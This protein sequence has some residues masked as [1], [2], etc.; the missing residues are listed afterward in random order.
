MAR[1]RMRS[2][3]EWLVNLEE[4]GSDEVHTVVVYRLQTAMDTETGQITLRKLWVVARGYAGG[5]ACEAYSA[6]MYPEADGHRLV[7]CPYAYPDPD[8]F[9]ELEVGYLHADDCEVI[10]SLWQK[11]DRLTTF[12][13][14]ETWGDTSTFTVKVPV[15][16][17][18]DSACSGEWDGNLLVTVSEQWPLFLYFRDQRLPSEQQKQPLILLCPRPAGLFEYE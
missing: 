9:A 6:V 5:G 7:G 16:E 12:E 4:A 17:G 13:L 11:A 18:S 14:A 1:K 2:Q 8:N 15:D 10:A 3:T